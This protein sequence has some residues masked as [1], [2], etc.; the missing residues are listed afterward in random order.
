MDAFVDKTIALMPK[1]KTAGYFTPQR[2]AQMMHDFNGI[3][4]H[5][6][7]VQFIADLEAKK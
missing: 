4:Q 6:R 7:F 2:V 3:R 5:P 1:W